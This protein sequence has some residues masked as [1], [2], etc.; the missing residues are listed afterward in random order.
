MNPFSTPL[1][2]PGRRKLRWLLA[3]VDGCWA[4]AFQFLGFLALDVPFRHFASEW[5]RMNDVFMPPKL[6]ILLLD[7]LP[8]AGWELVTGMGLLAL[9]Y[10]RLSFATQDSITHRLFRW[11]VV[12]L[13]FMVAT[14]CLPLFD[15]WNA[16]PPP[17]RS[18]FWFDEAAFL[19]LSLVLTVL[20][21]TIHRPRTQAPNL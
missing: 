5:D 15:L 8:E 21:F 4:F 20:A 16:L 17:R 18:L 3:I 13:M 11:S 2:S 7:L 10:A 14:A 19:A 6:T 1:E 12:V 9:A